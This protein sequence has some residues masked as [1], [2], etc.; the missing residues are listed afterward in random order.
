M[1]SNQQIRGL[2]GSYD[3][4]ITDQYRDETQATLPDTVFH[5][6]GGVEIKEYTILKHEVVAKH[7]HTYDHLS[8]LLE[9][10][11]ILITG[12]DTQTP[13]SQGQTVTI[14]ANEPHTILGISPSSRWMCI[15]SAYEATKE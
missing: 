14:K 15:H 2:P 4:V 11:V 1:K 5:S 3:M 9:G 6:A 10:E 7:S 12:T 8:I 13:V